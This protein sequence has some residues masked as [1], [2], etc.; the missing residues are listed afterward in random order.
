M[1][2]GP[3]YREPQKVKWP[4]FL[5]NFKIS[6]KKCVKNWAQRENVDDQVLQEWYDKVMEDV[7]KAVKRLSKK[8]K[9]NEEN[10]SE[11]SFHFKNFERLTERVCVRTNG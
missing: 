3:G 11:V 7:S 5:K 1:L 6:L 8:R 10:D 2:C 9:K 4:A